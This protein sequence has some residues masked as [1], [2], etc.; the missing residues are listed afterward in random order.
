MVCFLNSEDSTRTLLQTKE[1]SISKPV[2]ATLLMTV[3][4]DF[5]GFSIILPYLFFFVQNL[6]ASTFAY[7]IIVT[8]YAAEQLI[9]APLIGRL[10]DRYGR[11][12][13]LMITLLGS[14]G[15]YFIF[16]ISN[17][18][19]LLLL[20]RMLAGAFSGTYPL[21]Q[22]YV[23][24]VTNKQSRMKYMGFLAAAYGLG[25][26]FGPAVGGTLSKFYGYGAPALVAAVLALSNSLL[27]YFKLPESKRSPV[28]LLRRNVSLVSLARALRRKELGLLLILNFAST[29]AFV[30]LIV[31]LP[32]WLAAIFR[33]GAFE[34]GMV[35]FYAGVISITTVAFV[36]P[37]LSK[38]F[39]AASLALL[40]LMIVS[41]DY[42]GLGFV[43]E[44][45][46][47]TLLSGFIMAG[48]LAFGFSL[49][50]PAINTLISLNASAEDQ[51]RTLGFAQSAA[52]L[53]RVF[54]PTLAT[55]LLSLGTSV[56]A[57]GLVFFAAALVNTA[58]LPLIILFRRS[59]YHGS[60]I[61][62]FDIEV[63]GPRL[64][65][66]AAAHEGP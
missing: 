26:V 8:S 19:W 49:A 30:F 34:T 23:A 63:D 54:A 39:S 42:A 38:R 21:V 10:S 36:V 64:A 1:S 40:G 4:L 24:D 3:F 65:T 66:L 14:T 43:G 37:R 60:S 31:I 5:L 17:V 9:F 22:A 6:G 12:R 7:G 50:G 25:Y 2:L 48:M 32:P 29:F 41:L 35:L 62:N 52:S 45:T 57:T 15:S 53:A 51:G 28:L 47:T 16:G 20:S 55:I 18:L 44:A 61:I 27:T 58:T 11:R 13:V 46:L 56:G 33:F 59:K